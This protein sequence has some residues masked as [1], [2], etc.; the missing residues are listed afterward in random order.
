MSISA[1]EDR[2]SGLEIQAPWTNKNRHDNSR[3]M[4]Q[5]THDIDR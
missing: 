4:S 3:M 2:E 1:A 5:L